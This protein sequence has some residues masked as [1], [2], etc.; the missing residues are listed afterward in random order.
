MP[1]LLRNLKAK[2][3]Q[4]G[5]GAGRALFRGD[6]KGLGPRRMMEDVAGRAMARAGQSPVGVAPPVRA[7]RP[8]EPEMSYKKGGNVKDSKAMAKKEIAFMKKKG[9]PKSMIKHEKAEY[10]MKKGGSVGGSFRK[11]AD[12]VASKGKTKGKMVK[13]NKGGY[14]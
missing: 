8:V 12:G 7:N 2:M 5:D 11:A 6:A 14:C 3:D 10:G 1:K 13:M 9:A 4:M